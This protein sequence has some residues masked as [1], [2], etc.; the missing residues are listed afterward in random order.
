MDYAKWIILILCVASCFQQNTII[1]IR[2]MY[3]F[4]STKYIIRD[5]GHCVI[6]C[7]HS[8]GILGTG[9]YL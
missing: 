2:H 4:A 5:I 6:I 3:T 8:H 9:H 7:Q 1:N